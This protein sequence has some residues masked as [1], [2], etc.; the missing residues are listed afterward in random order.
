MKIIK[1]YSWDMAHRLPNHKGKC[2]NLHGH[3]YMVEVCL[4]GEIIDKDNASDQGMLLDFS[5]LK[6]IVNTAVISKL[7]HSCAFWSQDSILTSFYAT[8]PDLKHV[9]FDFPPTAEELAKWIYFTIKPL[10]PNT[11]GTGLSLAWIRL[12]ET[13]SSAAFYD[14]RG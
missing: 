14:D 3:T 5:D 13:E 10:I 12:H 9:V 2:R 1:K 11:Y 4:E 8:N 6:E 7:D